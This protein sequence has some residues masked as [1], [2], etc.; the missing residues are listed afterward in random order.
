[1]IQTSPPTCLFFWALG[2]SKTDGSLHPDLDTMHASVEVGRCSAG[3]QQVQRGIKACT[4]ASPP[5][6]RSSRMGPQLQRHPGPSAQACR[7]FPS[8]PA[9][10]SLRTLHPDPSLW[11]TEAPRGAGA[12]PADVF[13]SHRQE[14]VL[15][16]GAHLPAALSGLRFQISP[17]A[18]FQT[19][20]SQAELLH[21]AVARLAGGR[22]GSKFNVNAGLTPCCCAWA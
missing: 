2:L 3:Q 12:K 4:P 17:S 5:Q 19:N 21:D 20:S 10:P 16:G 1:M 8:S 9:C 13:S 15:W 7:A 18:F 22:C 6:R 11:S 14:Q